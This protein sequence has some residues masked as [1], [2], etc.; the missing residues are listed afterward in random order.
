MRY[1]S[2]PGFEKTQ[3]FVDLFGRHRL[4]T[5][6]SAAP[7]LVPADRDLMQLRAK[8]LERLPNRRGQIHL[9]RNLW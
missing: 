8:L 3:C 1:A 2:F 7:L 6:T 5:R 9:R 4:R